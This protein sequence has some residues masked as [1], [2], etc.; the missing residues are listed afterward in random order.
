MRSP[1]PTKEDCTKMMSEIGVKGDF[2]LDPGNKNGRLFK[3]SS[4]PT[5]V[6]L[7]KSGKIAAVNIGSR[8]DLAARI[9]GQLEALL[10]GKAIP[11]ELLPEKPSPEQMAQAQRPQV[12]QVRPAEMMVGQSAPAFKLTSEGG[13]EVSSENPGAPVVVLDFFSPKCAYCKRQMPVVDKVRSVYEAKGVRF[14]YVGQAMRSPDPTKDDCTK[15]M[16]EIGVKGDFAL[17]PGNTIGQLFKATG[18]P[19]MVVLDKS[20]KIAAVN[21]GARPDLE[22]RMKGQ[23]EALLSGKAIPPELLPPKPP[24]AQ[25]APQADG[26]QG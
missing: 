26:K 17:D 4:F 16:S 12:P 23:L 10:A 22:E 9:T 5:M 24:A 2:A 11:P 13:K 15:M 20:G 18:F 6:I 19:T 3:V 7:D 1:D 8:A 14:I 25:A 21:I